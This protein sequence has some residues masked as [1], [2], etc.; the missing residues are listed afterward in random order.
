MTA[1]LAV[2]R[3]SPEEAAERRSELLQQAQE[4]QAVTNVRKALEEGRA[5]VNQAA[6]EQAQVE[7]NQ[8][9]TDLAKERWR[10]FL[11]ARKAKK[12]LPME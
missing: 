1:Y 10:A 6:A 11:A 12:R 3:V 2:A 4:W 5:E 9:G 8:A 7:A